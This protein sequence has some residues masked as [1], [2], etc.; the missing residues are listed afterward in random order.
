MLR[1]KEESCEVLFSFKQN[2]WA[3]ADSK[4]ERKR[5]SSE[6]KNM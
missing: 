6:K 5:D 1:L 4:Q 3:D 2:D